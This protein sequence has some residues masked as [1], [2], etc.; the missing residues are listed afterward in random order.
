M[1]DRL[2]C[3]LLVLT[4]STALPQTVPVGIESTRHIDS[5]SSTAR[6]QSFTYVT[7]D[8]VPLGLDVYATGD[9]LRKKPCVLFVFGGAFMAGRWDDSLYNNYFNR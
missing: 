6:K 1:Q 5:I 3:F 7:K 9:S 8:L 2:L 4:A